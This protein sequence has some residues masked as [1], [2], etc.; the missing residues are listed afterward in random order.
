MRLF[1][2]TCS[3]FALTAQSVG[4][5]TTAPAQTT[6]PAGTQSA[7][8][9]PGTSGPESA[10][11]LATTIKQL[12]NGVARN[13]G[14]SAEKVSE[15]IYAFKP[16]PDVRSYGQMVGHVVD[17]MFTYCARSVEKPPLET[18]IEKTKTT[19]A[20]LLAAFKRAKDY[21][22]GVYDAMSDPGLGQT[23]KVGQ[24]EATRARFLI[25]NISHVNE[26]YGNLVTYMRLK[27]IV[28]PSTERAQQMRR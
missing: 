11:P 1:I 8:T 16:T 27:G 28:P 12:W 17:S 25:A 22:D 14:E 18:D 6:P 2:V 24:T 19:R 20:D 4:A 9:Q 21:C 23:I 10:N 13:M 7:P 15:D 3:I 26:H 5:Q